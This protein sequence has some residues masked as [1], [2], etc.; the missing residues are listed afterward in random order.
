MKKIISLEELEA[1]MSFEELV[2]FNEKNTEIIRKSKNDIFIAIRAL[3]KLSLVCRV[4][5]FADSDGLV[6]RHARFHVDHRGVA[7]R[8]VFPSV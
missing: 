2:L 4:N 7:Y 8:A 3:E 6:A 5:F 1:H